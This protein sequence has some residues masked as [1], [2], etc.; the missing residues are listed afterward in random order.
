MDIKSK[1]KKLISQIFRK[2]VTYKVLDNDVYFKSFGVVKD[3]TGEYK[4]IDKEILGK[5]YQKA[6]ENRDFEINKFWTRAAYFW[7]FIVLI[8]GGLITLLTSDN[9]EKAIDLRL[10]L[11]LISLGLLFSIAWYLVMKGSKSW[12][13]NWEAH[14]DFLEN[15]ISGPLYKTIHYKG[16]R[17]YSVSKINE[18]LALLVILVWLS[19]F[20][21]Y[22]SE[23]FT[24]CLNFNL[25]DYQA[26]LTFIITLGFASSMRFGY[27]LGIYKAKEHG[28]LD[29]WS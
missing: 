19:F 20:T 12:Q 21:Q 27:A 14:I 24:I 13:E 16:N 7:G 3:E 6:W 5:A 15:F 29:R 2:R 1:L 10:D 8:F 22:Y 23:N 9:S 17:F 4:V 26:T 28:F 11:Y 18:L 25:I